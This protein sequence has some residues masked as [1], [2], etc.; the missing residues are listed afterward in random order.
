VTATRLERLADRL[1]RAF[2]PEHLKVV[3]DSRRHAG[4]AGAADGRGHFTVLITSPKFA[5]LGTLKRHRLV[6]EAVGDLM[7]TDIHALSIQA[8]APGEA[9]ID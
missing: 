4:H 2:E 8:L 7:T 3:D 6:Y 5:E 9:V 1:Q